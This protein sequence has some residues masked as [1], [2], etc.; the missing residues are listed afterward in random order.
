MSI[1]WLT[2]YTLSRYKSTKMNRKRSIPYCIVVSGRP[3]I[4]MIYR[5]IKGITLL[6]VLNSAP[7]GPTCCWRYGETSNAA[8]AAPGAE[9]D[10][11]RRDDTVVPSGLGW[12]YLSSLIRLSCCAC[13]LNLDCM[14]HCWPLLYLQGRSSGVDGSSVVGLVRQFPLLTCLIVLSSSSYTH[15]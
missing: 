4:A 12:F 8:A 11:G 5:T 2:S 3:K 13:H 1:T 7:D 14:S 10:D 6:L 15:S 9:T